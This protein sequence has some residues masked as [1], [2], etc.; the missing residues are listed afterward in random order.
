MRP[1]STD[2]VELLKSNPMILDTEVLPPE[3]DSGEV[4]MFRV[5]V[6]DPYDAD[7]CF[8]K[9]AKID[10]LLFRLGIDESDIVYNDCEGL[11]NEG[12]ITLS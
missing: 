6:D 8:T 2:I 1:S 4:V 5:K 9:C 7:E 11:L 10:S 3:G 12:M